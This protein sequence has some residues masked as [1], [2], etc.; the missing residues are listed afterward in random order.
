MYQLGLSS[1]QSIVSEFWL[2]VA[3]CN[4]CAAGENKYLDEVGELHLSVKYTYLWSNFFKVGLFLFIY[5]SVCLLV[6]MCTTDMPVVCEDRSRYYISCSWN[7]RWLWTVVCWELN[8]S[9]LQEQPMLLTIKLSLQPQYH[10]ILAFLW[11]SDF[12]NYVSDIY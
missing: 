5:I 2:V 9:L 10:V 11:L 7:Y 6:Y 4:L 8:P 12:S 1:S 3:F